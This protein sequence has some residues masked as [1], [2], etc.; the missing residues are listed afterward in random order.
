MTCESV[1]HGVVITHTNCHNRFR[2]LECPNSSDLPFLQSKISL[3]ILLNFFDFKNNINRV[4]EIA[5][6]KDIIRKIILSVFILIF[7]FLS[8]AKQRRRWRWAYKFVFSRNWYGTD[9]LFVFSIVDCFL[10]QIY[11]LFFLLVD[12]FLMKLI[13]FVFPRCRN[14]CLFSQEAGAVACFH[15]KLMEL[16]RS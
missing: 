11:C 6:Q 1:Q 16:H 13:Q 15:R 10:V 12:C 8:G 4:N 14:N 3:A 5:K 2:I 7:L 9:I